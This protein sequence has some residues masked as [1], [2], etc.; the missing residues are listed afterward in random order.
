MAR[1]TANQNPGNKVGRYSGAGAAGV[2]EIVPTEREALRG[3][4]PIRISE[5]GR[6]GTGLALGLG[7]LALLGAGV[8]AYLAQRS[9]Q[10]KGLRP[11]LERMVG[12][13]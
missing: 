2:S 9:R 4:Q 5:G 6:W 12:L 1:N 7:A 13:R 11:R 10:P 3:L 8:A